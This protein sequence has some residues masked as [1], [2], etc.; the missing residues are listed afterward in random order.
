MSNKIAIYEGYGYRKK[1]RSSKR[2]SGKRASGGASRQRA[3]FKA[4]AKACRGTGKGFHACMRRKL[5]K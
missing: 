2:R 4:A 5:K 1:R 3:K